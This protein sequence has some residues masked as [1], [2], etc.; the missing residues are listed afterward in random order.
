LA[1]FSKS[2]PFFRRTIADRYQKVRHQQ[3]LAGEGDLAL[4]LRRIADFLVFGRLR[5]QDHVGHELHQV[6]LLGVR[7]HR[8][9]LA[10]FLLG[11]GKIALVDFGAVDLGHD[12][13]LVLGA[14]RSGGG[15]QQRQGGGKQSGPAGKK[16]NRHG[17]VLGAVFGAVLGN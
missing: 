2:S 1:S 9:N 3:F 6:V 4:E 8:R 15:E 16:G 13:V 12:R 7:R 17:A 14:Q 5:Y 10:G 11:D